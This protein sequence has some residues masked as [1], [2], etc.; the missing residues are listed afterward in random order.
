MDGA[1]VPLALRAR[2]RTKYVPAP[3]PVAVSAGVDEPVS[4]LARLAR[5]LADP[6]SSTY[7]TGG[8]PADGAVHVI[9]TVEPETAA[10]SAV[11]ALGATSGAASRVRMRGPIRSVTGGVASPQTDGRDAGR[12]MDCSAIDAVRHDHGRDT[13]GSDC[14]SARCP[15]P[16]LRGHF[17]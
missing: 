12:K 1:L 8:S 17:C 15:E 5:P 14:A 9:T 11:G 7:D 16:G 10:T 2:T 6:A 4:E 3:T 13:P